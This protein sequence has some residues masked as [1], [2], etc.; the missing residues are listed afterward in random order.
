MLRFRVSVVDPEPPVPPGLSCHFRLLGALRG[1]GRLPANPEGL[2][3]DNPVMDRL[4]TT[5]AADLCETEEEGTSGPGLWGE[6]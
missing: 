6:L 5:F 4:S 3:D 1:T 2:L